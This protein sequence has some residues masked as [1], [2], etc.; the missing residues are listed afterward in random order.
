MN[1]LNKLLCMCLLCLVLPLQSICETLQWHKEDYEFDES[2][3]L[4]RS[5]RDLAG[6]LCTPSAGLETTLNG[7]VSSHVFE[8]DPNQSIS[9]S[10]L[11]DKGVILALTTQSATLSPSKLYRSID[12]GRLVSIMCCCLKSNIYLYILGKF[13]KNKYLRL[14]SSKFFKNSKSYCKSLNY[15]I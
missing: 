5:R 8:N 13:I 9:L 12:R 11:G 15:D 7:S 3:V 1:K 2:T 4:K 6:T 10:W 14:D